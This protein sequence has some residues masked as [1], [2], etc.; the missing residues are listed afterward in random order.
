MT[1]IEGNDDN[2]TSSNDNEN[3]VAVNSSMEVE[4]DAAMIDR[5]PNHSQ[6]PSSTASSHQP[7]PTTATVAASSPPPTVLGKRVKTTT[8][9]SNSGAPM[10]PV[11]PAGKRELRNVLKATTNPARTITEFQQSHSLHTMMAKANQT[12][13]ISKYKVTTRSRSGIHAATTSNPTTTSID[14]TP[15]V[16]SLDTDSVMT[17]ISHL[18]I[19]QHHVHKRITDALLHELCDMIRHTS[20]ATTTTTSTSTTSAKGNNKN[21]PGTAATSA[22][23]D[24]H[25]GGTDPETTTTQHSA[26]YD[27]LKSCWVY[28]TTISEL[29]PILWTILKQL[30]HQTPRPVLL[31]L[32]ERADHATHSSSTT[33]TTTTTT[34]TL[35]NE[36]S[37]TTTGITTNTAPIPKSRF[38]KLK[39]AE[40]Y[41]PLSLSLKQLC[42]EVD[43]ERYIPFDYSYIPDPQDFLSVAQTT[44]LYD[45]I[46]NDIELYV[47]N[48]VL[49]DMANH[50]FVSTM[51]ER[52]IITTQRRAL[53]TSS[54]STTTTAAA[55]TINNKGSKPSAP[56][57]NAGS[58][59]ILTTGKAV[60]HLRHL[61]CS[62]GG[63]S[64]HLGGTTTTAATT[65][66]NS[67]ANGS[68]TASGG[69][70]SSSSSTMT[71]RPKLLYSVLSIL[72]SK[73]CTSG[74]GTGRNHN[75]FV[76]GGAQHLY[77]T[78]AADIL[79]LSA[80]GP[81]PKAYNDVLSFARTLDDIVQEAT[82][83][84]TNLFKLQSLLKLIFQPDHV[85]DA[86]TG[87]T[88]ISEPVVKEEGIVATTT[89]MIEPTSTVQRQLNRFIL[90][91]LITMKECDPQT[92]FLNP[93][94]DQ[95]A[96]GYSAIIKQPMSISNMEHKLK[97]NQYRSVTEWE[98]DVTLM[99]KNCINYNRGPA[100][101]WFRNEAN[102]QAK[103]F[104]EEIFPKAK[105]LYQNEVAK[106]NFIL[107]STT[108]SSASTSGMENLG[109]NSSG[110]KRPGIGLE[111]SPLQPSTKKRK[112]EREEYI[113][114]MPA[115][116]SMLLADPFVVRII[117]ARLLIEFRRNVI[118]GQTV[119]CFN[120]VVPSLLQ[121]L[122]I[123]RY[124]KDICAL[125]G[126]K[127]FVPPA[128]FDDVENDDDTDPTAVVSYNCLR[129][130]VP[131]LVRLIFE[132]ELDR[133]I[134]M[135]GDLH[136]A[137]QSI[138]SVA[139]PPILSAMHSWMDN[140]EQQA[141]VAIALLQGSIIH[142][143]LPGH[144]T[145]TSL[146]VTFPKFASILQDVASDT[147]AFLHDRIF[148]NSLQETILRHKTK[149]PRSARDA[150]VSAWLGWLKEGGTSALTAPAHESLIKLIN[151]WYALGNVLL[152]RDV[153][154]R[155]CT[156]T[157]EAVNTTKFA[158]LWQQ[159]AMPAFEPIKEQY[160]HMLKQLPESSATQWREQNG[161]LSSEPT[162]AEITD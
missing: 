69:G 65:T 19:S 44:L 72:M 93:V 10:F 144:H 33:T 71:Y 112:K 157:I 40:V 154:I 137:S 53:T 35:S 18:G 82:I 105:R 41:K 29:R 97:Q 87:S 160:E 101:Q 126:K 56:V 22:T 37:T 81:L 158:A 159:S 142:L 77:C 125:R 31:A 5:T 42:W 140:S 88:G 3:E 114:S 151:D 12:I 98:N 121:L 85:N 119:P 38:I 68:L 32:T 149:L 153:M 122:H 132:S 9:E 91:G 138:S 62:S 51:S 116:A 58:S 24:Q 48:P 55:T 7:Q 83:S 162:V 115:L 141:Y 20:S 75:S 104:R 2:A 46:L 67:N 73:Y 50:P 43:W 118:P 84:D 66:S 64:S 110:S 8:K 143:C 102:R 36:D 92:L 111:I 26:L 134:T 11:G 80:G 133:R 120:M 109:G 95:I 6:A 74:T 45:T 61:L 161:I 113:P 25:P 57:N 49:C 90:A 21:T 117:I 14:G 127:F 131:L 96:P 13:P 30:G 39:H 124:S 86:T 128:G 1:P 78:L 139:I 60:S 145:E 103:I 70:T 17:F 155:F 76:I 52:R 152:P 27:L 4:S 146:S 106:R 100:G 23:L 47:Q 136:Q 54:T 135:G 148:F 16:E 79:L 108:T 130:Y 34:T 59:K 150:I 147:S 89:D 63:H 99:F 94:T 15:N 28:T 129:H 123:V 107:S 156:N